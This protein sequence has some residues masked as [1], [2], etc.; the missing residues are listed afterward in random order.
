MV[1]RREASAARRRRYHGRLIHEATTAAARLWAALS[2]LH[3][4]ARHAGRLTEVTTAV[5]DLVNR[6]REG[7]DLPDA[8]PAATDPHNRAEGKRAAA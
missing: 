4:E 6:V 7:K 5:L 1:T 3:S 8:A 2:W